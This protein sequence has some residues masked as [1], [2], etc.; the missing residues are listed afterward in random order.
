MWFEVLK[1]LGLAGILTAGA[2]WLAKIL[3]SHLFSKDLEKFKSDIEKE[4]FCDRIRYE[5]MHSERAEVIK[6]LYKRMTRAHR[7]FGSFMSPLQ[8]TGELPEREKG[9][10][11]AK[12]ANEFTEYYE[13]NRIF[14]DENSAQDVDSLSSTLRSAW[15]K[16]RTSRAVDKASKEY[17]DYWDAAWKIIDNDIPLIKLEVEKKFRKI[18]G[19]SNAK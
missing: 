17:L 19:I 6:E 18:I 13:E 16:F 14:L 4:A 11:A 3:I 12:H 8:L 9:E 7:S 2:V 10:I 5:K 15:I 1:N